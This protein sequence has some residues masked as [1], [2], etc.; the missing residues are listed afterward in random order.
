[1]EKHPNIVQAKY[2][3]E[4]TASHIFFLEYVA[5]DERYGVDLDSWINKKGLSLPLALNFAISI[6]SGYAVCRG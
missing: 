6:L 1:L 2:V 4:I 3:T 5:G